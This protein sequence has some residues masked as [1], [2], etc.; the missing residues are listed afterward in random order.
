[1]PQVDT[2]PDRKN[3]TLARK[4]TNMLPLRFLATALTLASPLALAQTFNIDINP[5]GVP[6]GDGLPAATFGAAA[7]TPGY[8]NNLR[9]VPGL[10]VTLRGLNGALT[11]VTIHTAG[12]V[13]NLGANDSATGNFALLMEDGWKC[14][15]AGDT[16]T[17]LISGLSAGPYF[18]YTY[19]DRPD[20]DDQTSRVTIGGAPQNC[21]GAHGTNQFIP[22]VTH[23]RHLVDVADG[24]N[25]TVTIANNPNVSGS[26]A[27]FNGMQI[28]KLPTRLYVDASAAGAGDGLTWSGAFASLQDAIAAVSEYGGAIDE[29]W[30]AAGVYRPTTDTYRG[31]TFT[32]PDGVK[33]Y[34]GFAGNE[35]SLAQRQSASNP[36]YLNGAI[37]PAGFEDNSFHIVT[38]WDCNYATELDGFVIQSGNANGTFGWDMHGGA[39]WI[40]DSQ[41]TIRNCTFSFNRGTDGG[42]IGVQDATPRFENCTFLNNTA[43]QSGGAVYTLSGG[44]P[45]FINCVFRSNT[46]LGYTGG[47]IAHSEG[48]SLIASNCVFQQNWSHNWGGAIL[49]SGTSAYLA[50]C[51]LTDN[52]AE[53]ASAGAIAVRGDGHSL[54][55]SNST[56]C[57]NRGATSGGV[58]ALSDGALFLR[59]TILSGNIDDNGQSA[60]ELEQIYESTGGTATVDYCN[61]QG[62]SGALGGAGNFWAAPHFVDSDGPDNSPGNADD[63]FRLL[64]DSPCIDRGSNALL[65]GDSGDVDH[66]NNLIEPLPRDLDGNSRRIDD[67]NTADQGAGSAPLV[68]LGAYEF[69]PPCDL[70]GDLDGDADVDIQDLATLLSNFG[71]PSGATE[72]DGDL[73]GDGDVELADLTA[74]L[75]AFGSTCP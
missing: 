48:F 50:N 70:I 17:C 36:S 72:Q 28:Q 21:G 6:F 29:V 7:A 32:L 11:G 40:R 71:T 14:A 62:W 23:T 34:G 58:A 4:E 33:L 73:D 65:P 74:M 68:E 9:N 51:V 63:D 13:T 1:M 47:A 30:V 18:F 56:I 39:L 19:A 55:V 43:D 53:Y 5:G 75:S 54:F 16:V 3:P 52:E 26:R 24:Q 49:S 10:T 60:E 61:V 37:G 59:N 2:G 35:T 27:F 12:E 44:S 66:D 22:N 20:T 64:P 57:R 42:A 67:P 8:W 25:V 46:A 15:A 69:V 31:A 41:L 38:A 45:K